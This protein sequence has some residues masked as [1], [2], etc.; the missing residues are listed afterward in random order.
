MPSTLLE[1]PLSVIHSPRMRLC[2]RDDVAGEAQ[3][4][5]FVLAGTEW[6]RSMAASLVIG[7]SIE[8]E[9]TS[10]DSPSLILNPEE[11]WKG[12]DV[13]TMRTL[14]PTGSSLT[15]YSHML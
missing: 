7:P 10:S 11:G 9:H 14:Q 3:A 13:R 2:R 5:S 6:C 4:E 8:S 12:T 1:T 15:A